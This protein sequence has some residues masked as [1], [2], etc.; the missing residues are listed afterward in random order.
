LVNIPYNKVQTDNS[1]LHG[2]VHQDDM[3]VMWESG[4]AIDFRSYY[5]VMNESAHQEMPLRLKKRA[6]EEQP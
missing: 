2:D 1:N 5:G 3:L 6:S 4:Q